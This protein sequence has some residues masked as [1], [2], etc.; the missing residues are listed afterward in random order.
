MSY[1]GTA[2]DHL[3]WAVKRALTYFDMGDIPNAIA[4]F[5]SDLN[6]HD[7]TRWI[8]EHPLYLPMMMMDSERGRAA[9]EKS[10]TGWAV[11]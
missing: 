4:S 10:M 3:N 5:T 6:K 7:G 9:F 11:A 8:I 2:R 1:P